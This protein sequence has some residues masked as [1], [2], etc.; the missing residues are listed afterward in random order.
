VSS[1]AAPTTNAQNFQPKDIV[2]ADPFRVGARNV[3][4]QYLENLGHRHEHRHAPRFDLPGDVGRIEAA[5][6]DHRTREHR[7]DECGHRLTEHVTERQQVEEPQWKER[8]SPLAVLQHLAFDRDDVREDVAMG[9]DD[10]L[11]VSRRAGR[12][13]DLGDIIA[14]DRVARRGRPVQGRSGR[15]VRDIMEM[16]D[17]NAFGVVERRHFLADQNQLRLDDP[18]DTPEE[19]G[20]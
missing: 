17:G 2:S 9:D 15:R 10:A 19:R 5:H 3:F 1:G 13:D 8:P 20:R 6:E 7:R 16:P 4:A 18:A 12:K 14:R 11:R